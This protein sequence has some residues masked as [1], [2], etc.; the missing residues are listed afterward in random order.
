MS[1][2]T[3]KIETNYIVPTNYIVR[4]PET[5]YIVPTN[6]IVAQPETKYIVARTKSREFLENKRTNEESSNWTVS[7]KPTISLLGRSLEN[8]QKQTHE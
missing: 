3:D 8:V 7:S 4:Q 6:Y 2:L 5:N 1:N